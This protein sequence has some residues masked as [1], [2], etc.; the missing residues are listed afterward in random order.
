MARE[1]QSVRV[2]NAKAFAAG[3]MQERRRSRRAPPFYMCRYCASVTASC[4]SSCRRCSEYRLRYVGGAAAE[5]EI[6]A[7][8]HV[9]R[10]AE[11]RKA[12]ILRLESAHQNEGDAVALFVDCIGDD[13]CL[14]GIGDLRLID[15]R[16]LNEIEREAESGVRSKR[17]P[18]DR[19]AQERGG[20][21]SRVLERD[22][23]LLADA[24]GDIARG[25]E[26]RLLGAQIQPGLVAR[27]QPF[28]ADQRCRGRGVVAGGEIHEARL[29]SP[30]PRVL[31]QAIGLGSADDGRQSHEGEHGRH[32]T[33]RAHGVTPHSLCGQEGLITSGGA[34]TGEQGVEQHAERA[35]RLTTVLRTKA[36]HH[37]V[38]ASNR[39]GDR[40]RLPRYL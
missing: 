14:V 36:E 10:L 4:R 28:G 21:A 37:D 16:V 33:D 40:G 35:I 23:V 6:R 20:V 8:G 7:C 25:I 24:I 34:A 19:E 11:H 13:I 3:M 5:E 17:S 32:P 18:V 22:A 39:C 12:M 38:P 15:G 31:E 1:G 9:R 27:D 29:G 26:E 30:E 2:E